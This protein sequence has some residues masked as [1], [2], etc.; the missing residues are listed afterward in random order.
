MFAAST[1]LS[2][3]VMAVVGLVGSAFFAEPL[4][5]AFGLG[6]GGAVLVPSCS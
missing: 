1:R 2:L 4:A 5:A 6:Q 3:L